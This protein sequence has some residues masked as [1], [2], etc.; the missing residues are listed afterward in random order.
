MRDRFDAQGFN[1]IFGGESE[2]ACCDV[3]IDFV[4]TPKISVGV[5]GINEMLKEG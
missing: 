1:Y 2:Y 3:E 5:I 4:V